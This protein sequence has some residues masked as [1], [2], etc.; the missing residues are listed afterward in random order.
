[1]CAHVSYTWG[2]PLMENT[3]LTNEP[4][5]TNWG[6]RWPL[7]SQTQMHLHA[8]K[9]YVPKHS[10]FKHKFM[11]VGKEKAHRYTIGF[12]YP[13]WHKHI[14]KKNTQTLRKEKNR[15]HLRKKKLV[16]KPCSLNKKKKIEQRRGAYKGTSQTWERR[17]HEEKDSR[18]RRERRSTSHLFHQA[19]PGVK[20]ND[21]EERAA[22]W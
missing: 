22:E 21:Q 11:R 3:P 4:R 20:K 6:Y 19:R 13:H 10:F 2:H 7:I 1:M 9:Q 14:K 17:K 8:H 5:N 18:K 16:N 15:C 12:E